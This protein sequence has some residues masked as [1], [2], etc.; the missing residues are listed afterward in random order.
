MAV[1]SAACAS[2]A[3]E[4][5]EPT[6]DEDEDH[7]DE[8]EAA[9]EAGMHIYASHEEEAVPPDAVT[10]AE[11]AASRAAARTAR[12]EARTRLNAMAERAA[13]ARENWE[14]RI[15]SLR[16]ARDKQAERELKIAQVAKQKSARARALAKIFGEN[17]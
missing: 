15:G 6:D 16:A 13:V 10:A 11:E 12:R 17:H 7:E 8:A 14:V 5:E 1:S 4:A 3:E 9:R 2:A